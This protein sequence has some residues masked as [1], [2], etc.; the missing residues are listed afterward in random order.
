MPTSGKNPLFS[1]RL[2]WQYGGDSGL[3]VHQYVLECVKMNGKTMPLSFAKIREGRT[4]RCG[5][6]EKDP[7]SEAEGRRALKKTGWSLRA[8][9]VNTLEV[10]AVTKG[11]ILGH[12]S[13]T[14]SVPQSDDAQDEFEIVDSESTDSGITHSEFIKGYDRAGTCERVLRN[15]S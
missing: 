1:T 5:K 11:L 8:I 4:S 12:H 2:E 9:V 3:K 14:A 10:A 7:T 15:R 6:G 13:S